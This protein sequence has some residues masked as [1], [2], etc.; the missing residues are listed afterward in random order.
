MS[1]L[2][3]RRVAGLVVAVGLATVFGL[4]MNAGRQGGPA[5]R[6]PARA[7][8]E[9]QRGLE[10][11]PVP[12]DLDG[13]NRAFVGRGSYLVNAVGS[14]ND[15]HTCPSY[16]PGHN[17][18]SGGDGQPDAEHYLAGGVPF[19]PFVSA[20]LTP[21]AEGRPAGL[22]LDEFMQA[23]RTGHDPDA[24]GE[25]LQV[26][27]WPVLRNMTDHDLQAI[28]EFLSSVPPAESGTECSGAGE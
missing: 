25:V 7:E 18:Y 10:I 24:P 27:P 15:C 14:C 22:T 12:L 21:D 9:V 17:P 23:I 19:G 20:N 1:R 11:A 2:P 28:Y 8:T 4:A 16:E 6:L 5:H 13:R 3:V 26:M